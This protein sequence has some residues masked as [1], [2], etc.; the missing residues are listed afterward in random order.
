MAF[1]EETKISFEASI[2]EILKMVKR[3]GA[4]QVG[5]YEGPDRHE[6]HFVLSE[7]LIRFKLPLSTLND[8]PLKDGR[9]SIMSTPQREAR[10]AKHRRQRARS[11]LLVIKAKL[12]SVESGIETLEQAFLANVVMANG[13]TVYERVAEPIALEYK[14]GTPDVT[15]G[16]LPAPGV[17]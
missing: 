4:D 11:L 10:L 13:Q 2:A 12:E 9:N 7:R 8:I 6:I 1:A 3:A 17:K 16:L 14:T 15:M 5:N